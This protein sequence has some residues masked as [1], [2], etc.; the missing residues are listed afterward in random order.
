MNPLPRRDAT[1]TKPHAEDNTQDRPYHSNQADNKGKPQPKEYGGSQDQ[2]YQG[3]MRPC[4]SRKS[5]VGTKTLNTVTL[6]RNRHRDWSLKDTGQFLPGLQHASLQRR[7]T[8]PINDSPI[9]QG[10]SCPWIRWVFIFQAPAVQLSPLAPRHKHPQV[11]LWGLEEWWGHNLP[12]STHSR[13]AITQTSV[14]C[15]N[16]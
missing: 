6:L 8:S 16:L 1:A 13:S 12:P 11:R 9:S 7:C 14:S 3:D 2:L 4:C 15:V 10:G 5:G